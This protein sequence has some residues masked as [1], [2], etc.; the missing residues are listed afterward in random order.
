MNRKQTPDIMGDLMVDAQS[1]GKHKN[2]KD[3]E[4]ESENA[5]LKSATMQ[6]NKTIMQESNKALIDAAKEKTTYNLSLHTLDALENVWIKLRKKLKGEQR[7]TKTLIVE[8]AL[9]IV[10]NDFEARSEVSSLFQ[11]IKE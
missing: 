10:L 8:K 11:K 2:N 5:R 3:I 9:E 4:H 7:I 6:S 1:S